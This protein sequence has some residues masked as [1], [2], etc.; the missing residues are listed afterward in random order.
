MQIVWKYLN[1]SI[2]LIFLNVLRI[3]CFALIKICYDII[4][5][6]WG[7]RNKKEAIGVWIHKIVLKWLVDG[8][9][10]SIVF[11]YSCRVLIERVGSSFITRFFFNKKIIILPEPQFS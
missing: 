8:P 1:E 11:C 10:F 2:L 4:N 3:I 6:F 7:Y 9:I 5:L